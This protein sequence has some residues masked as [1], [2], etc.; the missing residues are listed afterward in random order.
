MRWVIKLGGSLY[1]SKYLPEWLHI[2]NQCTKHHIIIVPGGGP[3]ADQVRLADKKYSLTKNN[4]HSMAVLA[5]QQ[6]AHLLQSLSSSLVLADSLHEMQQHW[7]NSK[8]LI[9]EPYLMVHDIC[10]LQASWQITSDSLA[11]WLA[12]YLSA[13]RL[14]Y[15]KST[16]T[17]MQQTDIQYLIEQG[18]VDAEV[19]NILNNNRITVDFTHKSKLAEFEQLLSI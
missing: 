7:Q 12:D 17:V 15:I 18:C 14:S 1:A 16:E 19:P 9:W 10:E 5:M 13:D 3:F 6:Y 4:S 8:Q 11:A 2:I